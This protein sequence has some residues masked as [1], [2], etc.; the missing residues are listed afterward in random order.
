M[1]TRKF[2][3]LRTLNRSN[4][5]DS[6]VRIPSKLMLFR[7]SFCSSLGP[8]STFYIVVHTVC[9]FFLWD[10]PGSSCHFLFAYQLLW[11]PAFFRRWSVRWPQRF[12]LAFLETIKARLNLRLHVATFSLKLLKKFKT[13]NFK[14]IKIFTCCWFLIEQG[15]TFPLMKKWSNMAAGCLLLIPPWE[16][17]TITIVLA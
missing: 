12:E 6:R 11:L 4:S 8:H 15:M 2:V 3:F 14:R 13:L 1:A 9:L 10:L 5:W 16:K 17:K 7:G